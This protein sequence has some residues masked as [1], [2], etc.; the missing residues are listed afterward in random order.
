MSI[1]ITL[2]LFSIALLGSR[3]FKQ[4]SVDCLIRA[5]LALARDRNCVS[6]VS[7]VYYEIED[8]DEM[9]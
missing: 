1:A 5:Y 8:C 2:N 9:L 6:S 4:I 7:G 3:A